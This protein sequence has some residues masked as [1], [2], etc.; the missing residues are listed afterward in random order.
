MR[1][2][3]NKTSE[4]IGIPIRRYGRTGGA[5]A[6]APGDRAAGEIGVPA[7]TRSDQGGRCGVSVDARRLRRQHPPTSTLECRQGRQAGCRR[8]TGRMPL[9]VHRLKERSSELISRT[10]PLCCGQSGK[11]ASPA[12]GYCGTLRP[13]SDSGSEMGAGRLPSLRSDALNGPQPRMV[14]CRN[15]GYQAARAPA[16]PVHTEEVTGSIPIS[17]T[18]VLA[19]QGP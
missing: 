5:E 10:L 18:R 15:V 13:V 17:P 6:I 3:I 1:E 7:P 8:R 2:T 4:L 12:Q 9:S 14:T 11:R 16:C 19:G